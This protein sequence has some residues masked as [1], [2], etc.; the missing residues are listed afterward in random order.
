MYSRGIIIHFFSFHFNLFQVFILTLK[1]MFKKKKFYNVFDNWG[2]K[3]LFVGPEFTKYNISMW[4]RTYLLC[5]YQ[6]RWCLRSCWIG[7]GCRS[8]R[9]CN[10]NCCRNGWTDSLSGSRTDRRPS[11]CNCRQPPNRC[12]PCHP[13]PCPG[14]DR[15][16]AVGA[17]PNKTKIPNWTPDG[18]HRRRT[19]A[20]KWR[21]S[22]Q[23]RRRPAATE[24]TT[25]PTRWR[26]D[27]DAAGDGDDDSDGDDELVAATLAVIPPAT[28]TVR[29]GC[30]RCVPP[31]R[32][33]WPPPVVRTCTRTETRCPAGPSDTVPRTGPVSKRPM[34][35]SS[36]AACHPAPRT[37]IAR[38]N[39][40]YRDDEAC[41]HNRCDFSR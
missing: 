28:G 32:A 6:S 3:T 36:P 29:P 27:G 23:W 37:T 39:A 13:R 9:G 25:V 31:A 41:R 18:C 40:C 20:D 34:N 1:F 38:L 12:R 16:P 11:R 7:D 5:R 35:V 4:T 17:K 21:L 2:F 30:P 15:C 24:T 26:S 8:R 19:T 10:R 33:G 14:T 22:Q